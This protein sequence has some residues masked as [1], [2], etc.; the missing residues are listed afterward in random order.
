MV[1]K[2]PSRFNLKVFN[3]LTNLKCYHI[4]LTVNDKQI[5]HIHSQM[6]RN[7]YLIVSL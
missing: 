3:Q 6:L 5:S 1:V 4:T 2:K 7:H